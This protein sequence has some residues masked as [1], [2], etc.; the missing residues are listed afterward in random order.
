MSQKRGRRSGRTKARSPRGP[1]PRAQALAQEA[2]RY[3]AAGR[4]DEAERLCLAALDAGS[5]DEHAVA[6]AQHTLGL[7][8]ATRGDPT[9]AV[10]FFE[11][12]IAARPKTVA[13][14]NNLGAALRQLGDI[15]GSARAFQAALTCDPE[16]AI[17][18]NGLG[19]ARLDEGDLE[20]ASGCFDQA[21]LHEPTMASAR[22]NLGLARGRQGR[23]SEAVEAHRR[24][25][26]LAPDFAAGH[27][28]LASALLRLG[29]VP[30]AIEHYRTVLQLQPGAQDAAQ[31]LLLALHYPD[32]VSPQE[33][34][35]EHRAWAR[36]FAD[37]LTRLSPPHANS[38]EPD[39]RLRIGYVSPDFRQHPVAMSIAP[40]IDAHDREAVH[41]T[42]YANV[43]EPDH[44]TKRFRAS[45]D[46]WRPIEAL[47]DAAVAAQVRD[48]KID[49]LVDLA[50]HTTRNRL[51]VL[52]LKPAPVQ[53]TF[54]GYPDTT[55]MRAIDYRLT[56]ARADPPG[57]SDALHSERLLRL[58]GSFLSFE[59]P[60]DSREPGPPPS[61]VT[62]EI[63]FGS[64]NHLPKLSPATISLWARV[65]HAVP[66]STLLLKALVL[67]DQGARRRLLDEFA[68]HEIAAERLELVGWTDSR[69]AHFA[70]YARVDVALD[71]FPYNGTATTL[72]ALW[73]GVPVVGLAGDSHVSRVGVSILHAVGLPELIA[74][75]PDDYVS[76]AS[77]LAADGDRLTELRATLR[78]R[79]EGSPLRDTEAHAR[80]IESA[81]REMW[82][83]WCASEA[84]GADDAHEERPAA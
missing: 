21:V 48:D 45:A 69:D 79:I 70:L 65:L 40:L 43:A 55:G 53:V 16:N 77:R 14:H 36:R 10:A 3:F 6:E 41:V 49:I 68:R 20:A 24:A 33:R 7:V 71:P 13:Y 59:P 63:T 84:D 80:H 58:P 28:N 22:S 34:F 30:E 76:I 72:E 2:R 54:Q 11:Q 27:N 47:D 74:D 57:A 78:D 18:L 60:Q 12:A 66:G 46:S 64:F 9:E 15:A 62:G 42:C 5:S 52:A 25:L 82:H 17:A 56:D 50:G 35:A 44:V 38:R 8:A 23:W 32:D 83:R 75:G 81:Y 61:A 4:L 37:P 29:R 67:G 39:R 31:N 1:G 19:A 73:M 26:A 51:G